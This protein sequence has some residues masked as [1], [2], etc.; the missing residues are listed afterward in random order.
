MNMHAHSIYDI[1]IFKVNIEIQMPM[2]PMP[3]LFS[4]CVLKWAQDVAGSFTEIP[5]G[6]FKSLCL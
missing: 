5:F 3:R 2:G 4:P 1:P 6:I